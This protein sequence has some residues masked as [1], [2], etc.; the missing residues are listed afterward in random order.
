MR[1]LQKFVRSPYFNQREDVILLFD[2]IHK[3]LNGKV[4]NL[5]K[6][7]VFFEIFPNKKYNDVLMRQMMSYLYKIIQSIYY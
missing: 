6:E 3:S 4:P 5:S 7:K 2:W 1:E